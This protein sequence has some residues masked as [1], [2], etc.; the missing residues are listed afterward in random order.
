VKIWIDLTNSPHVNFFAGMIRELQKEHQVTLTCRPLANTI[1]LLNLEGFD[2]HV[3]GSHYGAS[4]VKKLLGFPVRVWQ[5]FRFLRKKKIDAAISHSSFYS[6]LAARLLRV[7]SIYL[8]D[9]EHASGNRI[10]FLCADVI[11]IPEFLRLESVVR[12]SSQWLE[13]GTVVLAMKGPGV[14]DEIA[15]A[16]GLWVR[17][18]LLVET[19]AYRLPVSGIP[20][21]LVA[22]TRK[23]S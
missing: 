12:F 13:V 2:Y 15:A 14:N 10:S 8:N 20:R 17:E 19:R 4:K 23:G 6:P 18:G 7:P 22:V 5:L 16:K 3:V 9:N 21:T 1:D 11:M